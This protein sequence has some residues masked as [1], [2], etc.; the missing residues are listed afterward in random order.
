MLSFVV[1]Q[2]IK[3]I[4]AGINFNKNSIELKYDRIIILNLIIWK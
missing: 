4:L 1:D 2:S 3:T